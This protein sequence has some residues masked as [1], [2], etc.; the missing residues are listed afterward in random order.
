MRS[1]IKAL[2]LAAVLLPF[3]TAVTTTSRGS[4][5]DVEDGSKPLQSFMMAVSMI[6]ISEIGDKTFL[7]AALMAMRHPRWL[8]F[9]SAASSLAIMTILSGIAGH[10]FISLIP[11]RLT[12]VL[13][14]LLFLVFGYKLIQEGLA[15]SKDA[16][17]EEELAEVEEELAATDMNQE[18]DDLETA[19]APNSKNIHKKNSVTTIS[20]RLTN[21]AS[22]VFSPIWVQIFVMNFLAEFG[23]RSQ[24]TIIAMASDTNY[25]YVIFGAV[26]GHLLCTGF[27]VI[28]GKILATKISMR[29]VTLGG[30][31]SFF[32]FGF[33][34]FLE[35]YKMS[36]EY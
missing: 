29:T 15:M 28:G 9:S 20:E 34:Y 2:S 13:A 3:V 5:S 7:I 27:A 33:L 19:G 22:L 11:E 21:L 30:A 26:V 24:I 4:G 35:A 32:V 31:I 12:H 6:G 10:T 14:G 16:G 1:V 23:D 17:V 8:V 18:L 36:E 25:W